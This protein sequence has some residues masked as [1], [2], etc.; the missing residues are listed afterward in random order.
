MTDFYAEMAGVTAELLAPTNA[1]GLGQGSIVLVR[2]TPGA[3]PANAWDPPSDPVPVRATLAGAA[4]GVSKELVGTEASPGTTIAATDLQI[5]VA[6]WG[7]A[8]EPGDILE[9]DGAPLTILAVRNI[10]AVG[11]VSAIKFVA[12]R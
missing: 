11:T 7:G 6:P 8:Y 1:G 3:P 2:L 4:S 9:L 5:V 12:R 10:P